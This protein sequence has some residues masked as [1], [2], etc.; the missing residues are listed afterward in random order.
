M[1]HR[2][3]FV[4]FVFVI[5]LQI[6]FIFLHKNNKKDQIND[7]KSEIDVVLNLT[8]D[9]G[10]DY[11][12]KIYFVGDSTTYHFIKAGIDESHIFV[13]ES[14]TLKLSSNINSI[15]VGK[16]GVTIAQAIKDAECEIVIITLGVNGADS[17][18]ESKYKTY[19]KFR[20]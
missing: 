12:E 18:S 10:W 16:K 3:I 20:I 4:L 8:D 7:I 13:P 1:R 6:G 11:I 9:K 17:F 5:F 19:Y 15:L 14:Y 2:K